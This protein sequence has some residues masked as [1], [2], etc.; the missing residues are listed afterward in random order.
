MDLLGYILSFV[1][2]N[3]GIPQPLGLRVQDLLEKYKL[4]K[5]FIK[6]EFSYA[7]QNEDTPTWTLDIPD[8]NLELNEHVKLETP[9]A[10]YKQDYNLLCQTRYSE[11]IRLY[12]DGSKRCEGVDAA[13]VWSTGVCM[14]SLPREASV[15]SAKVH[16]IS[17]AVRKVEEMEGTKFVGMSDS[18]SVLRALMNIRNKHPICGRLQHD[19]QK[20]KNMNK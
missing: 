20:V 16:A 18:C 17:M 6:P 10:R 12:T 4:R 11:Y 2:R 15:F 13:V 7:L 14:A 9:Q 8:I 19:I 1:D 5:H 3:K